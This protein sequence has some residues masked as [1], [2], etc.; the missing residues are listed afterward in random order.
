MS[1]EDEPMRMV[2]LLFLILL[3]AGIGLAVHFWAVFL[4]PSIEAYPGGGTLV[5]WRSPDMPLVDSTDARC[6]RQ[7]GT[8]T[9]FCRGQVV[10]TIGNQGI[11]LRLP[12]S[13]FLYR[14]SGG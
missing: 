1:G 2:V 10:T 12:F 8:V 6:R 13:D 7:F 9:D 5:V 3:A 4:V 14:Y 11:L